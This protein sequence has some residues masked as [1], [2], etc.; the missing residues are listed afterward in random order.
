MNDGNALALHSY[1]FRAVEA[2]VE[3]QIEVAGDALVFVL[4]PGQAVDFSEAIQRATR[5]WLMSRR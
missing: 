2:G 1:M 3:V 5:A 4:E